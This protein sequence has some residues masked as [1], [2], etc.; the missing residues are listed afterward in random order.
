MTTTTGSGA[1]G[2]QKVLRMKTCGRLQT[3]RRQAA[4]RLRGDRPLADPYGISR[5][6]ISR[7]GISRYGISK[8]PIA[9]E[10]SKQNYYYVVLTSCTKL[11]S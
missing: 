5:Y 8:D 6:G 10:K 11:G 2:R 7:Y 1:V 4:G 3:E 9:C